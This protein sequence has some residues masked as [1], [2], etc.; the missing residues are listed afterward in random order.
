ML[1]NG[2]VAVSEPREK[3]PGKGLFA[4][5]AF[6]S[7]VSRRALHACPSGCDGQNSLLAVCAR[8][9]LDTVINW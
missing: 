6:V 4:G 8:E 3:S 9:L 2:V 1:Q 7:C 5:A